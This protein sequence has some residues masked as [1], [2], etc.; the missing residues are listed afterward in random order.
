MKQLPYLDAWSDAVKNLNL[1]AFSLTVS[2]DIREDRF[3]VKSEEPLS[4]QHKDMV[5]DVFARRGW[6]VAIHCPP[7]LKPPHRKNIAARIRMGVG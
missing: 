6:D 4:C 2:F 5:R 7:L 1:L 3:V